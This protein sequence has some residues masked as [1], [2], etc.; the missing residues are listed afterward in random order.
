MFSVVES[1][2]DSGSHISQDLSY[3]LVSVIMF[4][5]KMI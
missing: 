3:S 5:G 2:S 1:C 4:P